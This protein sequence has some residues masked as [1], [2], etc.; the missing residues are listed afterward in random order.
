MQDAT[1]ILQNKIG[2]MVVSLAQA[3]AIISGQE[4][5]IKDLEEKLK[6]KSDPVPDNSQNGFLGAPNSA[7]P[8]YRVL[9][10]DPASN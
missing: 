1:A 7:G 10:A 2:Q 8:G 5:R 4:Q 6:V 9:A 3:E